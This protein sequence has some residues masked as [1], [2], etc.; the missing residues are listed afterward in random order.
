MSLETV[1]LTGIFLLMLTLYLPIHT[2]PL[3]HMQNGWIWVKVKFEAI[4][5]ELSWKVILILL[6][7]K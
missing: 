1:H 5:T 7:I 4:G 6:D 3:Q 2:L